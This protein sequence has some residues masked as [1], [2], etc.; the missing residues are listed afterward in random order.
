MRNNFAH[1]I[2]EELVKRFEDVVKEEIRHHQLT[3]HRFDTDIISIKE[4]VTNIKRQLEV[5]IDRSEKLYS[6]IKDNFDKEKEILKKDFDLQNSYLG[7]GRKKLDIK[8]QEFDKV[9]LSLAGQ[10]DFENQ[11]KWMQEEL[12]K[13][14]KKLSEN[15]KRIQVSIFQSILNMKSDM[16]TKN[17]SVT[18][19][20]DDIR[21]MIDKLTKQ[22]NEYKIDST[23]VLRELQIYKKSMFIIEKKIENLYTL[24]SRKN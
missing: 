16:D 6:D 14:R 10:D 23:G 11:N 3:I 20:L 13:L 8:L 15:E 5:I 7:E 4:N 19:S 9:L 12:T 18:K 24:N 22:L 1:L 2:K 21:D 17:R